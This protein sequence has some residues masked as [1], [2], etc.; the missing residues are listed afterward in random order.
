[1]PPMHCDHA[2]SP[3]KINVQLHGPFPLPVDHVIVEP[4]WSRQQTDILRE[5]VVH[6]ES[7]ATD[8]V[9]AAGVIRSKRPLVVFVAFLV[10]DFP[11]AVVITHHASGVVELAARPGN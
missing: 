6:P 4:D 7:A 8:E 3:L 1:M 9:L 11:E 10:F 5:I 2:A